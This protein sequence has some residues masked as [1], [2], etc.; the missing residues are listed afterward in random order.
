MFLSKG[1]QLKMTC[2]HG[3]AIHNVDNKDSENRTNGTKVKM[4]GEGG[5][6]RCTQYGSI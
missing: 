5:A 3:A 1:K 2:W 4:G 6:H